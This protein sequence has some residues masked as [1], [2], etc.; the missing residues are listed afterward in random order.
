[1]YK[2]RIAP[3]KGSYRTWMSL[4]PSGRY[5]VTNIDGLDAPDF[6]I[7]AGDY[8]GLMDRDIIQH[9][10]QSRQIVITMAL[11]PPYRE[12]REN[13]YKNITIGGKCFVEYT[14]EARSGMC[15]GV[16]KSLMCNQWSNPQMAQITII[17][18]DPWIYPAEKVI[19][20]S[21]VSNRFR[22]HIDVSNEGDA[23][24]NIK[25]EVQFG[26]NTPDFEI[27]VL[28][29]YRPDTGYTE[30][31]KL[32]VEYAFLVGDILTLDTDESA[33]KLY[34]TR[35]GSARLIFGSLT[36][37]SEMPRVPSLKVPIQV[38]DPQGHYTTK[39]MNDYELVF[40]STNS[41]STH[42][43]NKLIVQERMAGV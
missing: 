5:I 29:G 18:T 22:M 19:Y 37:D 38:L 15:S 32:R 2:L 20:D 36:D 21:P 6:N 27:K 9:H 26:Y 43:I 25:A 3:V 33:T 24:A 41:P 30:V 40:D 31:S 17:C 35:D 4:Q 11:Q 28:T 14:G 10:M 34:L 1:M 16:V 42:K 23:P 7:Q 13:L 12:N 8:Y 39:F